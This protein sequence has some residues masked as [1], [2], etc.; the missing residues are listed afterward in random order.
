MQREKLPALLKLLEDPSPVVR[1][2]VRRALR[3]FGTALP[4]EVAA[5]GLS[6]NDTQQALLDAIVRASLTRAAPAFGVLWREWHAGGDQ[7]LLLENALD[8]LARVQFE[9]DSDGR[10]DESEP[11]GCALDDLAA[12]FHLTGDGDGPQDLAHWLFGNGRFEG[13]AA[14]NYYQPGNGNLLNVIETGKGLPLSLVLILM[15]VGYRVGL[16]IHGAAFPGH[17]LAR[18]D[19]SYFDCYDGGRELSVAEA[20]SISRAAPDAARPATIAEI[21]ARVLANLANS[22]QFAG[23]RD[24]VHRAL[25]FL[26][27]LREQEPGL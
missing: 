11:L 20:L 6:P 15:L 1:A 9:W 12:E 4:R 8:H 27:Q 25:L 26:E 24:K 3:E 17:F 7:Y 23:E 5:A 13:V 2:K 19:E 16:R 22:Y 10:A 21:V 18:V 14:E